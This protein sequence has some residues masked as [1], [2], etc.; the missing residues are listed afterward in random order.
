M[1]LKKPLLVHLHLYYE[2]MWN[3]MQ[4]YLQNLEDYPYE[5]YVTLT[6][7]NAK[8]IEDIK[9]FKPDAHI[10]TV[11]NKGYDV[12]PFLYIL[13]QVNLN[14]YAYI[15][16]LH[17]KNSQGI[18]T[19]IDK[20]RLNRKWWKD[21][22]LSSLLGS[23]A[24]VKNNLLQL[25]NNPKLG[26]IGS[27]YLI[28]DN[29][30]NYSKVEH[31]VKE[32]MADLG[33]NTPAKITFV[34]GTMFITRSELFSIFKDKYCENDFEGSVMS[35]EDGRL[36]HCLERVFGTYI[37]TAGYQIQ[38]FDKRPYFELTSLRL[39]IQ[40]FLFQHKIT[41]SNKLIIKICG[42]PVYSRRLK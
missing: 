35:G 12:W 32:I 26:M 30:I 31:K 34:S 27:R 42:I 3:E 41:K 37:T 29:P 38:G 33:I 15:I 39:S 22:L 19:R 7:R 20:W 36:S 14:D 11:A 18:D 17:T 23:P 9:R 13:N 10:F 6:T 4:N 40:R 1:I 16:K 24:I 5:L 25:E 21:L 8:I 28:T 2:D